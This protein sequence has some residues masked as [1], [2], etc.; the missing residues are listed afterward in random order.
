M[1]ANPAKHLIF[2][3]F[4]LLWIW[5]CVCWKRILLTHFKSKSLYLFTAP[6]ENI[7]KPKLTFV[8]FLEGGGGVWPIENYQ[9][10]IDWNQFSR[11]ILKNNLHCQSFTN[12]V[13]QHQNTVQAWF[14]LQGSNWLF[15]SEE[16]ICLLN[17][18]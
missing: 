15:Y 16:L 3:L 8:R 2:I 9:L 11:H 10:P 4:V 18:Y 1:V 7:R 12:T 13:L 6:P 17:N 14:F 5:T